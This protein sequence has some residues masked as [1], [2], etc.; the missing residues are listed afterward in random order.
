MCPPCVPQC[1]GK[2][3]GSDGCGGQ[4]GHPGEALDLDG[5]PDTCAPLEGC[6]EGLDNSMSGSHSMDIE[7]PKIVDFIPSIEKGDI[8]VLLNANYVST[9]CKELELGFWPAVPVSDKDACD[10]Q[11]AACDC[12]VR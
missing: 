8:A 3:C 11:T 10:F 12:L 7:I 9:D 6:E 4:C 5:N 2:E 1:D